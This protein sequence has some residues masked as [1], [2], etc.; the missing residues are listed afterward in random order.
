MQ[1]GTASRRRDPS[2]HPRVRSSSALARHPKRKRLSPEPLHRPPQ[3]T[4]STCREGCDDLVNCENS[5][6]EVVNIVNGGDAPPG[7]CCPA[8]QWPNAGLGPGRAWFVGRTVVE[9]AVRR[10]HDVTAFNRGRSGDPFP[11]ESVGSPV[12]AKLWR[13]SNG[14]PRWDRGTCLS[15]WPEACRPWFASPP[16]SWLRLRSVACSCRRSRCIAIGPTHR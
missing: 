1:L 2:W 5:T 10:G 4:T 15:T 7:W 9:D 12:I 14:S 11:P 16:R 3:W 8:G 13:I 6:D